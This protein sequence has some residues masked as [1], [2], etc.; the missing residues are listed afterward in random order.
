MGV[1]VPL[2]R[3]SI[4]RVLPVGWPQAAPPGADGATAQSHQVKGCPYASGEVKGKRDPGSK[5]SPNR[6][7]TPC[8]SQEVISKNLFQLLVFEDFASIATCG[9]S[10]PVSGACVPTFQGRNQGS[11]RCFLGATTPHPCLCLTLHLWTGSHR[12]YGGGAGPRLVGGLSG[13]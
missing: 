3:S 7:F 10:D 4:Y 1:R 11:R 8:L 12:P 9:P 6:L 2:P 5:T 13:T